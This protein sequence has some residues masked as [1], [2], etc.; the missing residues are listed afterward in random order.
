LCFSAFPARLEQMIKLLGIL[1]SV[2][3]SILLFILFIALAA[4]RT[5][6][7]EADLYHSPIFYITSI[8]F[9]LNLFLCTISSIKSHLNKNSL[10]CFAPDFIH[11]GVF[12]IITGM[13]LSLVFRIEE[14]MFVSEGSTVSIFGKKS[15]NVISLKTEYYNDGS[16]RDWLVYFSGIERPLEINKPVTI[17]SIKLY[18]DQ[19]E[20]VDVLVTENSNHE[21]YYYYS[22]ETFRSGDTEYMFERINS[23][24]AAV[25]SF[26]N[27]ESSS[28]MSILELYPEQDLDDL[29]I[30]NTFSGDIAGIRGV[31]DPGFYPVLAGAAFMMTGFLILLLLRKKE[32]EEGG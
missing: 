30:A 31:W 29:R 17:S 26:K 9:M 11:F 24:G 5:I 27:D 3:L 18:L 28:G 22:G 4:A 1:K 20:V 2:R 16:V 13:F 32:P 19:F 10:R 12:L 6:F 25:L 23:S 15:L 21:L 14:K 8:R 7:Q